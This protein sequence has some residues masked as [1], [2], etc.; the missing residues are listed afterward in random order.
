MRNLLVFHTPNCKH[1]SHIALQ[2]STMHMRI[3]KFYIASYSVTVSY[4]HIVITN[5]ILIIASKA[6]HMIYIYI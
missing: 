4:I 2:I 3:Y 6:V 5:D 1:H